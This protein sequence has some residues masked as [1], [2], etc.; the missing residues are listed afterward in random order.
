MQQLS[1]TRREF[2]KATA[3]TGAAAAF[4]PSK[5]SGLKQLLPSEKRTLADEVKIVKTS[6]RA[7]IHNCGVLAH[8]Q[9]GRVIKLEGNPEYPMSRGAMCAKGLAGIQALYHPNRMKYPMKRVG[10][11]GEGKWQRITWDEAITTIANKLMETRD[12]YGAEYVMASTGGGGNPAGFTPSRFL[13]A[14]GS[15]NFFEPG[16]AQCYLPRTFI[17]GL[18]YGGVTTSIADSQCLELYYPDDTPIK[19]LAIWGSVPAYHAPAGSGRCVTELRARGVKTVVVDPRFT[20]DAAKADVWLPI[21]PG[22][23]TALLMSWIKYIIDQGWDDR[24]FVA[25][26]TNGPF[27]VNTATKLFIREKD[28]NPNG[29]ANT[30]MVWDQKTNSAKPFPFPGDP[31]VSPVLFGSFTVNGIA[32]K[33][34]YQLLK[35]RVDEW[36]IEKAAQLCWVDPEKVKEGAKLYA[37]NKPSGMILGVATDQHAN[38]TQSAMCA[39]ILDCILGNVE[40]PGALMQRFKGTGLGANPGS[41]LVSL[42]PNEQ[43]LKR[44]G[45]AEYKA[46]ITWNAAH[47]PTVLNAVTTGKPYKPRV[48]LE[49]SGN[50]LAMLGNATAWYPVFKEMDFVLHMYMYPTSFSAMADILLPATEWLETNYIIGSGNM[51]FARQEVVRT[52]EHID[53]TLFWS[54]LVKK[55][56]DMGHPGC[57]KALDPSQLPA[58]EAPYFPDSMEAAMDNWLKPLKITWADFKAKGSMEFAPYKDYKTYGVYKQTNAQ[59]GKPNGFNTPSGKLEIY[60]ES[61]LV[62]GRTGMVPGL[63]ALTVSPIPLPPA[64]KDYDPLPYYI[65][66]GESPISTPDIAKQYPLVITSGRIPLFHHGTLRNIPWLRELYPVPQ[67]EINPDTAQSLGLAEGDWAWIE[68]QRGKTRGK[69]HLNAAFHP[70]VVFLERFWFPELSEKAPVLYGYREASVNVLT[71]SDPPYSPEVGTYTLRGFQVKVSKATEGA[72]AGVW[73]KPEEFAAWLPKPEG[74]A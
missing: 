32:V 47:I 42:L 43:L 11:R 53:E 46:L 18:V 49:R 12:K 16:C 57:K 63:K 31:N 30:Y 64:S 62:F 50:K 35:D 36:P 13:N 23:D 40:K 71:K 33:P 51:I 21:R 2:L 58:T 72:P 4:Y 27:L 6:C 70:Q 66:P 19:T 22:S 24:E 15:P 17:Y 10:E 61:L 34:A 37:A 9:N 60:L 56:A 55:L 65:E 26:W 29:D 28:V 38:S 3:V 48:W 14:F 59:T 69:V 20:P 73:Q 54:R 52:Y 8:V 7:C 25:Q 45:L 1:L 74:G 68:S 39:A 67:L 41:R 5:M 44:L